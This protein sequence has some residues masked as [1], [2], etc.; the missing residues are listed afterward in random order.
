MEHEFWMGEGKL[1]YIGPSVKGGGIWRGELKGGVGEKDTC[2]YR[3]WDI[4]Y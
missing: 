1:R 2:S 4:N 3:G